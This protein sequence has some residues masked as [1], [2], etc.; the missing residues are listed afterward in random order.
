MGSTEPIFFKDDSVAERVSRRLLGTAEMEGR[1]AKLSRFFRLWE[2]AARATGRGLERGSRPTGP[3]SIPRRPK[4]A[5][6]RSALRVRRENGPP[7]GKNTVILCY[8]RLPFGEWDVTRGVTQAGMPQGKI[9]NR[10]PAV[11]LVAW[12]SFLTNATF[13]DKFALRHRKHVFWSQIATSF[14]LDFVKNFASSWFVTNINITS[15]WRKGHISWHVLS[16]WLGITK[17]R[18]K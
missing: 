1:P 12:R 18:R 17:A 13:R 14:C 3:R 11:L 9:I 7:V 5:A 2:R 10:H 8:T 15:I 6:R 16:F 4:L